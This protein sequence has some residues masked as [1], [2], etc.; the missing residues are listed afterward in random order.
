MVLSSAIKFRK[1]APEP[2]LE[3]SQ[4]LG[5]LPEKCAYLGNRIIKDMVGCKRAGFAL[6]IILEPPDEPHPVEDNH[7]IQPDAVIHSLLDLLGIFPGRI[8]LGGK[9]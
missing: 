3:A 4:A 2:F 1:P 7:A 5:V 9:D 6:G 8:S